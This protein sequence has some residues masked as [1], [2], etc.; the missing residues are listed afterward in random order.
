MGYSTIPCNVGLCGYPQS[1]QLCENP[2]W[3]T[4]GLDR[5]AVHKGT[6]PVRPCKIQHCYIFSQKETMAK[7]NDRAN[8]S[9]HVVSSIGTKAHGYAPTLDYGVEM[10]LL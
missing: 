8:F 5:K 1:G 9:S 4:A 3:I 10:R 6:H 7:A 2:V